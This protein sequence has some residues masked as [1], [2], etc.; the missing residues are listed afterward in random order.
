MPLFSTDLG[1]TPGSLEW[2]LTSLSAPSHDR[3]VLKTSIM[4]IFSIFY[5]KLKRAGHIKKS[6]Y[7]NS[8]SILEKSELYLFTRQSMQPKRTHY[9][10]INN[11]SNSHLF[12]LQTL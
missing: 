3:F 10:E 5:D 9:P 11:K 1:K 6:T 7:H 12:D 8:F 4:V 2:L